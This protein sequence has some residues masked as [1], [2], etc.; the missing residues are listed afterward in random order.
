MQPS[1]DKVPSLF[2][3]VNPPSIESFITLQP[4]SFFKY[5]PIALN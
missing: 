4:N 1:V 2:G 5:A 3:H